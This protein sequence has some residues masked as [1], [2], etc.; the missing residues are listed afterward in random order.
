MNKSSL[1]LLY[2]ILGSVVLFLFA[3]DLIIKLAA[4]FG[5]L[6]LIYKGLT[7]RES[8]QILFYIHRFKDRF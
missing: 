2:I 8:H 4:I 7:L 5:G 1:G 6:Y 3:A